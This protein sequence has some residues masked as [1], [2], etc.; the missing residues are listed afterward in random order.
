[1]AAAS[2]GARAAAPSEITKLDF[3]CG[4]AKLP[5][6]VG[7]DIFPSAGVDVVHDFD[8]FPYPFPDD[9]FDEVK[10]DNSLEHVAD[11]LRTV[12]ELHRILKPGGMLKVLVPHYSGP[13]AYGDPTHRTF[14]AW[15]TFDRF[16]EG[17]YPTQHSGML[18]MRKRM[19]GV[20]DH[21]ASKLKALPKAFA[22]RFP[23]LY[24][25]RL[26]WIMPAQAIYYEL[27]ALKPTNIDVSA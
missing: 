12:E 26:C 19:F 4:P 2:P 23:T 22:N 27:E 11:F 8:T 25:H 7:M 5:G 9:T 6:F 16:L 20:P 3:G 14:F 13:N 15:S 17:T 1:M 24:E 21:R 10:C 18:R